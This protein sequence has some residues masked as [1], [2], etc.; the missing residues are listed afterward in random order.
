M[1]HPFRTLLYELLVEPIADL[2]RRT[3][4]RKSRTP[5]NYNDS[6]SQPETR[7]ATPEGGTGV[8]AQR[9]AIP[10]KNP[11]QTATKRPAA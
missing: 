10:D 6:E 7:W 2:W 5:R 9:K 3:I 11:A 4:G 8:S 1:L